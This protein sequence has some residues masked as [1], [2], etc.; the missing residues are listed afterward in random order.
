MENSRK[1]ETSLIFSPSVYFEDLVQALPSLGRAAPALKL[2]CHKP[3]PPL[4]EG[5]PF[6]WRELLAQIET[7]AF[8]QNNCPW[9]NLT[10]DWEKTETLNFKLNFSPPPGKGTTLSPQKASL[11]KHALDHLKKKLEKATGETGEE[12]LGFQSET[13]G[14]LAFWCLL[15]AK[16]PAF[17]ILLVE[18]DPLS[19]TLIQSKLENWGFLVTS[20]ESGEQA[21]EMIALNATQHTQ[22]QGNGFDLAI[23]D[24]ILPG[25][26]GPDVVAEIRKHLNAATLPIIGLSADAD[27][28]NT[29]LFLQA[30]AQQLLEKNQID[31]TL[32]NLLKTHFLPKR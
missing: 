5:H 14:G 32:H 17:H 21:L 2:T 8:L 18:D 1:K 19:R 11:L 20:M 9:L 16:T 28:E 4:A 12:P 22:P 27:A 31:A 10:I 3:L 26:S 15:K 23:M 7:L 30:G 6:Y 29:T 13:T 24:N 25:M